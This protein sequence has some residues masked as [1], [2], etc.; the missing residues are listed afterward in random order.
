MEEK[1]EIYRYFY[2]CEYAKPNKEYNSSGG[3]MFVKDFKTLEE[4]IEKLN[5]LKEKG[6][7]KYAVEEIVKITKR[8]K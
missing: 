1:L 5:S 6:Y 7:S 2:L 4:A 8:I 3:W